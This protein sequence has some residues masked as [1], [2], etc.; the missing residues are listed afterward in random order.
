MYQSFVG[1]ANELLKQGR[2]KEEAYEILW[3]C[4]AA[5][6]EA[7]YEEEKEFLHVEKAETGRRKEEGMRHKRQELRI[8]ETDVDS[9][10][11]EIFDSDIN[12]GFYYR[13]NY[14]AEAG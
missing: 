13:C 8:H 2:T 4:Y 7:G 1:E 5:E 9:V 14:W 6:F 11:P 10:V 3:K 12:D